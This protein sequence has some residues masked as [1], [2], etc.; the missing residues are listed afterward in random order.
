MNHISKGIKLSA[1]AVV[2]FVIPIVYFLQANEL[3]KKELRNIADLRS[4]DSLKL[5]LANYQDTSLQ[6]AK[7]R[8][9]EAYVSYLL[10]LIQPAKDTSGNDKIMAEISLINTHVTDIK[11]AIDGLKNTQLTKKDLPTDILT[12]GDF[13]KSIVEIKSGISR[14]SDDIKELKNRPAVSLSLKDTVHILAG[15]I[16]QYK[17]RLLDFQG[18]FN[19]LIRIDSGPPRVRRALDAQNLII[20]GNMQKTL[21]NLIKDLNDV[22]AKFPKQ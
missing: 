21:A 5:N 22:Y 15:E 4:K 13:D 3:K 6:N 2:S 19:N 18:N 20:I 12:R 17:N 10:K 7:A 8:A 14:I 11:N 9:Q 16:D 1:L